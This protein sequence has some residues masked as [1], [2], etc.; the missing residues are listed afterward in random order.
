MGMPLSARVLFAVAVLGWT[1]LA[2]AAKIAIKQS[3]DAGSHFSEVEPDA[4]KI[5]ATCPVYVPAYSQI[6]LSEKA[7]ARLAVTL[8]I[9]NIDPQNRIFVRKID[10]FDTQGTLV[11]TLVDGLF[12]LAPMSTA[13]FVIEQK[14][15]RGGAGA[16]FIVEWAAE[17][18][19]SQPIIEAIMAGYEGTK[20]LSFS[21][22]GVVLPA[23][24]AKP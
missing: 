8:S 6:Y 19:V 3:P 9:R 22:R 1:L 21:S 15:M 11:D 23:C 24:Q 14:D 2:F 7:I 5:T 12:A 13:S 17:G 10:Y 16:N 4:V 18:D 20:G